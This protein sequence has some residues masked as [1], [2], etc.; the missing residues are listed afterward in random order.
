[1][2]PRLVRC[3]V[4]DLSRSHQAQTETVAGGSG[5]APR[6]PFRASKPVEAPVGAAG[7]PGS[8]CVILGGKAEGEAVLGVLFTVLAYI[9]LFQRF[10]GDAR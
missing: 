5:K 10:E 1:M 9:W 3:F 6:R 4:S 8:A 2:N 7:D